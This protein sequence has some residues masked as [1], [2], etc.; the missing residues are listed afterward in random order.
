[1]SLRKAVAF[2]IA[3]AITLAASVVLAGILSETPWL[4]LPFLFALVTFTTY[5]GTTRKLGAALLLIQVSSCS[6]TTASH[7]HPTKSVGLPREIR[8]ER[9]RFR[10]DCSLRQ[11]ALAGSRAKRSCLKRWERALR[12]LVRGC[13]GFKLLLDAGTAAAVSIPPP[14]SENLPAH[15]ELLNRVV[16]EGASD[17]RHAILL[18]AITRVR[19]LISK[20]IA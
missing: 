12:G 14:T 10:H 6:F 17:H 2:L 20:W 4:M 13:Y 5:L 11:L 7:L 16:A 1:M 15:M 3:E 18:A 8:R 9:D 19:G